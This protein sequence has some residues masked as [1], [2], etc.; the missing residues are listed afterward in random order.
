[1]TGLLFSTAGFN[2]GNFPI[3][4]CFGFGAAIGIGGGG[5]AANAGLCFSFGGP[6]VTS[7]GKTG[8]SSSSPWMMSSDN[9]M[10][11]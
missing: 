8:S 4:N 9:G 7:G 1:M 2:M 11:M 5:G 10:E 6:L 3:N